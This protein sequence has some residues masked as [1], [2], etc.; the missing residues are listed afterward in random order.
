[1][2]PS[3]FSQ[4]PIVVPLLATAVPRARLVLAIAFLGALAASAALVGTRLMTPVVPIEGPSRE[5]PISQGGAARFAFVWRGDLF[6]VRADGTDRR[7]LTSGPA[8][9]ANPSWSPDGTRI[10]FERW[11][12][13]EETVMVMDIAGGNELILATAAQPDE[14]CASGGLA[15]SPEATALIFQRNA[16]LPACAPAWYDLYVVA[17][18]GSSPAVLLLRPEV[19][20]GMVTSSA[21]WSPDGTRIALVGDASV[22]RDAGGGGRSHEDQLYVIEVPRGGAVA[23]G[24][25]ARRITGGVADGEKWGSPRWSPDGTMLAA[26][27]AEDIYVMQPDGSGVRRLMSGSYPRWSPDGRQIAFRLGAD[28]GRVPDCG[29]C[30]NDWTWLMASDGT[31][32]RRLEPADRRS[33]G[34]ALT[35]WSPDGT[36]LAGTAAV[37][38][39]SEPTLAFVTVLGSS[40]DVFLHADPYDPIGSWQPM[41]R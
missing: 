36:R 30:A 6:M 21:A 26:T 3:L 4:L 24:L 18:D 17:T 9:D 33:R 22:E 1:M 19:V 11:S 31:G 14:N 25:H 15:W 34:F 13:G 16:G 32:K 29:H 20:A 41:K 27:H 39:L 10:A 5:A 7:Q 37:A 2:R 40:P 28:D 12:R 23:G 8:K 35:D 38:G